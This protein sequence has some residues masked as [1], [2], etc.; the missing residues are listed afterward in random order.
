[1]H[2]RTQRL[3]QLM[4]DNRVNAEVVAA[5][6]GRETITVRIW[7]CEDTKRVI[8]EDALNLLERLVIERAQ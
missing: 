1:M 3:H 8:P 7:R 5:M 4:R 6:L 2:A